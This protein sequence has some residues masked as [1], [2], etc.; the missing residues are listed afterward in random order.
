MGVF[1]VMFNISAFSQIKH[2]SYTIMA[3]N[4]IDLGESVTMPIDE[5]KTTEYIMAAL[6]QIAAYSVN[7]FDLHYTL[8]K[9]AGAGADMGKV[10]KFHLA[11]FGGGDWVQ[12]FMFYKD[13][14][15]DL[16]CIAKA[17]KMQIEIYHGSLP[18]PTVETITLISS[19][20]PGSQRRFDYIAGQLIKAISFDNGNLKYGLS[21]IKTVAGDNYNFMFG[22]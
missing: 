17:D 11:V 3:N 2:H 13:D 12:S 5:T 4:T 14:C 9:P 8:E 16:S 21:V 6:L 19:N 20:S 7:D 15:N 10:P 18:V 1:M 22:R